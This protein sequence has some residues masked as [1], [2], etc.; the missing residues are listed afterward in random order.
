ML[1]FFKN[2]FS[3]FKIKIENVSIPEIP[4]LIK[5]EL[6][7]NVPFPKDVIESVVNEV[8]QFEDVVLHTVEKVVQATQMEMEKYPSV[9]FNQSIKDEIL[10][11]L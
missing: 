1:N 9:K 10:K 3:C 2:V 8:T 4:E 6:K 5:D 7:I 11:S